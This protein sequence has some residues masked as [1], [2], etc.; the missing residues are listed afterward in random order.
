MIMQ[1]ADHLLDV[2]ATFRTESDVEGVAE[3]IEKLFFKERS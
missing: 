2:F 1:T 3:G